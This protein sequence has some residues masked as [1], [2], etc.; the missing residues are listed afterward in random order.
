LTCYKRLE[1]ERQTFGML[2]QLLRQVIIHSAQLPPQEISRWHHGLILTASF[3]FFPTAARTRVIASNLRHH[4][5]LHQAS[6][7][8]QKGRGGVTSYGVSFLRLKAQRQ[9]IGVT[10]GVKKQEAALRVPNGMH[11]RS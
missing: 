2:Q 4:P 6:R 1:I 5:L 11:V 10:P 8:I 9:R 3:V 7:F